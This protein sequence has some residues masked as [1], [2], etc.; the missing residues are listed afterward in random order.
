M[1]AAIVLLTDYMTQNIARKI[2]FA[3]DQ[4][5]K[6]DFH[7]SLLPAHVSLKQPFAFESM[8]RL[9]DYFDALAAS[10]SPF[11][12]ELDEIYYI[13]WSGYGILGMSVK[14]T[15]ILRGLHNRL[16][17]ELSELF[18]DT[19]AP[20]DGDEYRFHMTIELG[21]IEKAN[22]YR[23]YFD[24]L[25]DKR[26]NLEFVAKEMA[27]FYYSGK[28]PRSFINYRVLPLTGKG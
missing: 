11:L 25:A 12:V 18:R 8:E 3:L 6:I 20:H 2:V 4:E 7:G 15:T 17:H 14:E 13:D 1:K 10:I 26:V 9:E 19:S 28:G 24:K 16:N 22:P 5:Y 21:K 23:V 27:L